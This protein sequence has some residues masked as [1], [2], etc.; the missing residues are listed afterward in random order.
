MDSKVGA[1]LDGRPNHG[2]VGAT[3]PRLGMAE[4][5]TGA[6]VVEA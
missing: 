1:P 5:N 4:M 3:L 6:V 2:G